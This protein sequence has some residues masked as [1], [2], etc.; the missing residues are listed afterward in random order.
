VTKSRCGVTKASAAVF[1]KDNEPATSGVTGRGSNRCA[2]PALP[3]PPTLFA[4][5]SSLDMCELSA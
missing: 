4:G 2:M 5:Q 3:M 1:L